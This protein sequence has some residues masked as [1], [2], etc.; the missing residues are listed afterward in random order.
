M[1]RSLMLIAVLVSLANPLPLT[2][3]GNQELT[4]LIQ[5]TTKPDGSVALLTIDL[6]KSE[7]PKAPPK[8]NG[9][10]DI[11]FLIVRPAE[12]L[13]FPPRMGTIRLPS[14]V[15]QHVNTFLDVSFQNPRQTLMVTTVPDRPAPQG[16]R[17]LKTALILRFEAVEKRDHKATEAR[18]FSVPSW[19]EAIAY[20][21]R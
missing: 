8:T 5:A 21:G 3:Q 19:D 17:L 16:V 10:V 13:A 12:K 6:L 15:R 20:F 14:Q 1:S 7:E 4:G 18:F 9:F 11:S 2:G